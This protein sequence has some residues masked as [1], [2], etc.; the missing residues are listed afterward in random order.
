MRLDGLPGTW[1]HGRRYRIA[2]YLRR[3]SLSVGGYELA[4]RFAAGG[5]QAGMLQAADSGRSTVTRDTAT[6]VAYAHHTLAGIRVTADSTRWELLWTAPLSGS[7]SVEFHAVG[8]SGNDD[9]SNLGDAVYR[10]MRVV[11]HR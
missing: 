7:G 5:R 8:V 3:D 6:G 9:N 4:A 11:P 1:R 2:V 10:V